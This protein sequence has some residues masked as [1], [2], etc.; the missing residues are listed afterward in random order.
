MATV[1]KA[2]VSIFVMLFARAPAVLPAAYRSTGLAEIIY[3]MYTVQ[4]CWLDTLILHTVW[5]AH[6]VNCCGARVPPVARRS[7]DSLVCKSVFWKNKQKPEGE[8]CQTLL[9][10]TLLHGISLAVGSVR[11]Q[12]T[13][14][15]M[16]C[17][18]GNNNRIWCNRALRGTARFP[19]LIDERLVRVNHSFT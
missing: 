3:N 16:S 19:A 12:M 8:F 9:N 13:I 15:F 4:M 11:G 2:V 14:R 18:F 1:W 5:F 7:W 6:V 10:P 17:A